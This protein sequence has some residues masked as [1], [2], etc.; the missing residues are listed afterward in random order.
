MFGRVLI[1]YLGLRP[2]QLPERGSSCIRFSKGL[3]F[4]NQFDK[5]VVEFLGVKIELFR[6]ELIDRRVLGCAR[7]YQST[8][9][10]QSC[11]KSI[12]KHPLVLT[13]YSFAEA[14]FM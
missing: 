14:S 11:L 5:L 1:G 13:R 8:P 7:G 12:H 2:A 10:A 4:Y 3:E 6:L 9:P